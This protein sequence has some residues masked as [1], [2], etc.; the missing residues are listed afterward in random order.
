MPSAPGTP[1]CRTVA[2]F[3]STSRRTAVPA[4]S[5]LAGA[6]AGASADRSSRVPHAGQKVAAAGGRAPQAT[7]W[8]PS[9]SP[10]AEVP[11]VLE[12]TRTSAVNEYPRR[13]TVSM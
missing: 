4:R 8:A 9:R 10:A 12:V 3:R 13:G 5:G 1:Q 7:Q 6:A 2:F 11:E